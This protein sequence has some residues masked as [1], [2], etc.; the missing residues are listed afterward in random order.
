MRNV[1]AAHRFIKGSKVHGSRVQDSMMTASSTKSYFPLVLPPP[2]SA[3][4]PMGR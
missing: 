3:P 1:G 2:P 4:P